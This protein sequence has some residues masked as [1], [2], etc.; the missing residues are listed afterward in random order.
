[1]DAALVRSLMKDAD[2]KIRVQALRA[3][4]T[5]FKGGDR[6]FAAD[7]R[8]LA[9]DRDVEVVMQALLTSN[10]LKLADAPALAKTAIAAN[11]AKGVQ[12]VGGAIVEPGTN[13]Y[14]GRGAAANV[15]RGPAPFT[16]DEQAVMARG[17]TIYSQVCFACHGDD[18]RGATLA[19][20]APGATRAPSLVGSSRV[21]GH[22]DYVVHGLLG[23]LAGPVD[24]QR[25]D[26][27]MIPMGA[28][29]DEWIADV[30]SYVRNSWGN[31]APFVSTADVA[32]VRAA[33]AGRTTSWT[34]EEIE[35]RLPKALVVNDL[36][37][38]T[39]SHNASL[40][41]S[42]L[43]L[44][45][46]TTGAPQQAGMWLQV[47]LPQPV[48]LTEIHFDSES[49]PGRG[50]GGGGRGRA[51]AAG[52]AGRGGPGGGGAAAAVAAPQAAPPAPMLTP[53][54]SPQ[55]G[56]FQSAGGW[57]RAYQVQ[58]S[59]DGTTWSAPVAEG[60]G[61]GRSTVISFSPVQAKFVRIT[62]TATVDSA[63]PW[64]VMLLRL[65]EAGQGTSR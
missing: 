29:P 9:A 11:K 51:G 21:L 30:G 22:R 1:M 58:V 17:E 24:G 48:R 13:Q 64:A 49:A 5:L 3:S 60:R 4:E 46:W 8:S 52:E 6:S 14:V 7:Y 18:G 26:E 50:G 32:R 2:P 25:Y 33:S 38:F 42:A 10:L 57:P 65:Y 39:A 19:G 40:A 34:V 20:A 23:G 55:S 61:T 45:P 43:S 16:T 47:E 62:Q 53:P 27:T 44:A 28:N 36:W 35:A 41:R 63:P 56:G 37:K 54:S 15:G 12:I 59:M 31:R